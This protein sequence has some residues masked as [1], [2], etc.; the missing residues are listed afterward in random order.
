MIVDSLHNAAKYYSLHPAFE[1]AFQFLKENDLANLAD[2]VTQ[3]FPRTSPCTPLAATTRIS[4]H[5]G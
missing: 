3:Y 4:T 5:P 1:K 2:G